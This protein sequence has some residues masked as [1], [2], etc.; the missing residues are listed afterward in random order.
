MKEDFICF[1]SPNKRTSGDDE[2]KNLTLCDKHFLFERLIIEYLTC[3]V[4][5]VNFTSILTFWRFV[6][7]VWLNIK[8]FATDVST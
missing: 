3:F 6:V 5:Q 1:E 2:G 4:N 8:N 7:V